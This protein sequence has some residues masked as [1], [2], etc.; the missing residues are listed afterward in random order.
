MQSPTGPRIY[1]KMNVGRTGGLS[2][3]QVFIDM[4]QRMRLP[5]FAP[6]VWGHDAE[7][8]RSGSPRKLK[9][10]HHLFREDALLA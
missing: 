5:R 8:I 7:I 3:R 4:G 9:S 10:S 2:D 6:G 1:A